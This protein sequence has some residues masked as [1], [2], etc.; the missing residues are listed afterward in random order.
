MKLYCIINPQAGRGMTA[1]LRPIIKKN[2]E[3]IGAEVIVNFTQNAGHAQILAKD[4]KEIRVDRVIAVGGDGTI[5]EVINGLIDSDIPLGIIP[6]GTGNDLS[7][8]LNLPQDPLEAI[9]VLARGKQ[10]AINIAEVNGKYFANVA[11]VGF[12]AAVANWVN[13]N[14]KIKGKLVYYSAILYNIIRN[15]HYNLTINLDGNIIEKEC[16]LVAV[17]NGKY[18]G[19]GQKIAPQAN[20][21]DNLFDV[22]IVSRVSRM[23]ILKTLPGIREGKHILNPSVSIYKA[24]NVTISSLNT[25]VPVQADGET[26]KNLPHTF[27][28]SEKTLKVFVP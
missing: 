12:D 13:K 24:K 2:I 4:A 1:R 7:R 5:N 28:I 25:N 8:T 3:K 17:A 15:K 23:D 19:A 22:V 14:K 11:S 16:T 27:R 26:L 6:T 9:I 21:Y 18:Y 20:L 10:L